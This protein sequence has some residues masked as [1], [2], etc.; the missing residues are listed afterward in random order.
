MLCEQILK[1]VENALTNFSPEIVDFSDYEEFGAGKKMIVLLVVAESFENIRNMTRC[2]MID[3]TLK[4]KEPD[5]ASDYTFAFECFTPE[6]Y[7]FIRMCKNSL[8]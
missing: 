8:H 5:L 1:R 7:K 6:E 2:R 4:H 3:D